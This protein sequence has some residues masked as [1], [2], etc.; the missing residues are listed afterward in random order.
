MISKYN[1]PLWL[2]Q[3]VASYRARASSPA[4]APVLRP[5]NSPVLKSP[6]LAPQKVTANTSC[7]GSGRPRSARPRLRKHLPRSVQNVT[8]VRGETNN[9]TNTGYRASTIV[10]GETN[11]QTNTGYRASTI[12]RGETNNQTNT[13]YRASTIVRGETNKHWVQGQHNCE[14]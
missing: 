6:V 14:R 11:K 9:R 10:R 1:F 4:I 5:T 13:G 2:H 7:P 8:F 3:L 12:V